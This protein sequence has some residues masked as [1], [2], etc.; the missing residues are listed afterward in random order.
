M[1][2]PPPRTSDYPKGRGRGRGHVTCFYCT[3][4]NGRFRGAG[5]DSLVPGGVSDAT[6]DAAEHPESSLDAAGAGRLHSRVPGVLRQS[7][8]RRPV[9]VSG[10]RTNAADA[11][12]LLRSPASLSRPT[13]GTRSTQGVVRWVHGRLISHFHQPHLGASSPAAEPR[14]S[15]VPRIS[16]F[17][18]G[19]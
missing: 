8:R 2:K 12:H 17:F 13:D 11:G 1:A 15:G 14:L 5:A 10:S 3:T 7:A 4:V 16:F 6:T 9:S 18:G 19:V